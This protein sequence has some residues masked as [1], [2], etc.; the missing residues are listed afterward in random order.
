MTDEETKLCD[1]YVQVVTHLEELA[2]HEL[3]PRGGRRGTWPKLLIRV[4]TIPRQNQ[5]AAKCPGTL[6]DRVR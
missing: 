4:H 1:L 6:R 3:T 2:E 5:H